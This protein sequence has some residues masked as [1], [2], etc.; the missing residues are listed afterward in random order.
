MLVLLCMGV[1]AGQPLNPR[2]WQHPL[3]YPRPQG[4]HLCPALGITWANQLLMRLTVDRIRE[5]ATLGPSSCPARTLRVVFAPHL[6][7]CSCSYT[8]SEEGVRGTEAC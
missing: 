1:G 5:E 2:E 4:E 7:P 6:P 3:L 8:V